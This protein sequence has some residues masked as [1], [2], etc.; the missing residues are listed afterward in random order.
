MAVCYEPFFLDVKMLPV[1][2]EIDQS[3]FPVKVEPFKPANTQVLLN[4]FDSVSLC[5]AVGYPTTALTPPQSPPSEPP[6]L[7]TLKPLVA[8]QP[9]Y[10]VFQ[11]EQT[12]SEIVP[13]KQ[14]LDNVLVYRQVDY[15]AA[16]TPQPDIA[17]E[18]AVVDELV[19]SHV[20]NMQWSSCPSSPCSNSSSNSNSSFEDSCSSSDPEWVPEAVENLNST[21]EDR[22]TIVRKRSKP[23]S[24]SVEDKKSRKKEQN[25]NAATRYRLKKK[26]EV[27]EILTEEKQLMQEGEK[28]MD[29]VTDIQREIKYLKGL[30]RDLFKAKGLIN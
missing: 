4:E 22:K 10:P 15:P 14:L 11:D 30:M 25:K 18:L 2:D 3:R 20:E 9:M 8:S 17:H 24:R 23:Y 12:S 27:E 16:I 21:S 7:T 26:A 28:L 29:Q 5:N 19:R 6:M 13:E 1:L